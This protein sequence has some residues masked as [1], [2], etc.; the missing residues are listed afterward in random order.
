MEYHKFP[1]KILKG[2]IPWFSWEILAL[3]RLNMK[4]FVPQELPKDFFNWEI[5]IN[6]NEEGN[7]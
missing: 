2:E 4:T 1:D 7:L 6:T 3:S 5:I